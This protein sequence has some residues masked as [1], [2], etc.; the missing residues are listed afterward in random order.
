MFDHTG[1]TEIFIH[2]PLGESHFIFFRKHTSE[3]S[4]NSKMKRDIMSKAIRLK[5]FLKLLV[6]SIKAEL[7]YCSNYNATY[8]YTL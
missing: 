3:E 5:M 1:G 4:T 8:Y 7:H 2:L 6:C